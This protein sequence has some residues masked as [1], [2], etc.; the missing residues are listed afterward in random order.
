MFA[1]PRLAVVLLAA[2]TD[3]IDGWLA[4]RG[5]EA[6]Y[7]ARFD[8]EADSLLT[9]GAAVAAVRRG[10]TGLVL[11]PAVARYAVVAVRDPRTLT[12]EE[13]AWDRVTGTAQ[14]AV[15]AAALAPWPFRAVGLLA[16]P[17]SAVR[18]AALAAFA[19]SGGVHFEA[20]E[21][22]AEARLVTPIREDR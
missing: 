16:G 20:T 6:G 7:G 11:L 19:V 5:G 22:P 10:A 15:L 21:R 12:A 4:R 13:A 2:A 9:L 1:R 14:M 18:C 17:V 3:W 8:L